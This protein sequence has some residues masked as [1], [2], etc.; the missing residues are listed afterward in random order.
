MKGP[1]HT[2]WLWWLALFIA[3]IAGVAV[4]FIEQDPGYIDAAEMVN[5]VI[6]FAVI[7]IGICIISATSHWWLRR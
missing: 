4:Y 6:M 3:L 5:K 7:A 2:G 1:N